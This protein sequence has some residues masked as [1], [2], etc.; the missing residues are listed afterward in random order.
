M[1]PALL[2]GFPS[3]VKWVIRDL[4]N[5]KIFRERREEQSERIISVPGWRFPKTLLFGKTRSKFMCTE[6]M[7]PMD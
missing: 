1:R 3:R 7:K 6:V 2:P 4:V 5:Q